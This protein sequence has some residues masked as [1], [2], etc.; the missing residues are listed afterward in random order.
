MIP[1]TFFTH[2]PKIASMVYTFA[3]MTFNRDIQLAVFTPINSSGLGDINHI[4]YMCY[5]SNTSASAKADLTGVFS[6]LRNLTNLSWAFAA[7]YSANN[8]SVK[9]TNPHL[10][11]SAVFPSG[12]YN[13]AAYSENM[14]Y[15]YAFAYFQSNVTHE[16]T[17]TLLDNNTTKNYTLYGQS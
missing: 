1:Q 12:V 10:T 5:Y 3:G 11:F 2:C 9:Q 13:R 16:A 7:T 17:K 4:F 8:D 15:S 6:T 14:N